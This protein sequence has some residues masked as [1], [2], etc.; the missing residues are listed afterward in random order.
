MSPRASMID[1]P[2]SPPRCIQPPTHHPA[3]SAILPFSLWLSGRRETDNLA[4]P[5]TFVL[6]GVYDRRTS[7]KHATNSKEVSPSVISGSRSPEGLYQLLQ[8]QI[9]TELCVQVETFTAL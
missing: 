5:P 4:N 9:T 7:K 2:N 6:E 1:P 3:T 8:D